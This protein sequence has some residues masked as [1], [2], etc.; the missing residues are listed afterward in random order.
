MAFYYC[1]CSFILE[2]VR[3]LCLHPDLEG[4]ITIE[5]VSDSSRVKQTL[6]K[7]VRWLEFD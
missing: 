7:Y 6:A 3:I 5:F 1:R 4:V 2:E